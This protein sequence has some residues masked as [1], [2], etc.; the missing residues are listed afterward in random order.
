MTSRIKMNSGLLCKD[1]KRLNEG[2]FDV[3]SSR[4]TTQQ[5]HETKESRVTTIILKKYHANDRW[6]WT[7]ITSRKFSVAYLCCA[8]RLRLNAN[9]VFTP[10]FNWNS[11]EPSD[12]K[13]LNESMAVKKKIEENNKILNFNGYIAQNEISFMN[14]QIQRNNEYNEM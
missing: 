13:S 7:L 9:D 14:T 11:W 2:N 3:C 12:S 5:K 10:P 8:I 1:E 6:E 4:K